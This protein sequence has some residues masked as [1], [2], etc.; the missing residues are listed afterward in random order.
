MKTRV[1]GFLLLMEAFFML[2]A[3]AVSAYYS[4]TFGEHDL[5]SLVVPTV[6]TGLAGGGLT[7]YAR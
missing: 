6:L 4:H 3:C 5:L 2:V 7:L 1:F